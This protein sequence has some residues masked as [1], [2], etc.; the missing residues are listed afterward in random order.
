MAWYRRRLMTSTAM[1]FAFTAHFGAQVLTLFLLFRR[2]CRKRR[3]IRPQAGIP[4]CFSL[5]ESGGVGTRLRS[6]RQIGLVQQFEIGL[7]ARG[8]READVA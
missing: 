6:L 5:A 2:R 4:T 1:Q 7:Q 3:G 8:I